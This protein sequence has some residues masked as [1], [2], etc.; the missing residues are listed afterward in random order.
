VFL[1]DPFENIFRTGMIPD[2]V[3]PYDRDGAA[4]ADLQAIG[5]GALN[6]AAANQPQ[7]LESA[8]QEFPRGL[9]RFLRTAALLLAHGAEEYLSVDCAAAYAA[10]RLARAPDVVARH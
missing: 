2:T 5:L 7:F 9:A 1:D 4:Y 10:Q 3:R 8:L 6:A